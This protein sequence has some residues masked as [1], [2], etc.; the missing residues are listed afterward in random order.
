MYANRV[1][2]SISHFIDEE[3]PNN[4]WMMLSDMGL[5]IATHYSAIVLELSR[6]QYM[7]HLPLLWEGSASEIAY[8]IP[9]MY[10]G[11]AQHFIQLTLRDDYP[12]PPINPQWDRYRDPSVESLRELLNSRIQM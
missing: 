10:D 12:L 11:S 3:A 4:R 5:I 6:N 7:M 1:L 9:I 2:A 8:F